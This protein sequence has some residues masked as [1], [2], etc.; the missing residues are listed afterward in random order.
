M[1]KRCEN[2]NEGTRNINLAFCSVLCANIYNGYRTVR[3]SNPVKMLVPMRQSPMLPKNNNNYSV[4]I[5]NINN[6]C[7]SNSNNTNQ[8][9]NCR[10]RPKNH[11]YDFC[12][13]KCA[14]AYQNRF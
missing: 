13:K 11:P 14:I 10:C 3:Q 12:C 1:S 4:I 9:I 8:C 6:N 5:V 7:N 2:C